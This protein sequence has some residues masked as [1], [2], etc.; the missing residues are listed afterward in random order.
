M[1]LLEIKKRDAQLSNGT[2]FAQG[3]AGSLF[4]TT[5]DE[6]AAILR[7]CPLSSRD[8]AFVHEGLTLSRASADETA[9][10]ELHLETRRRSKYLAMLAK[11][12]ST[13]CEVCD[14]DFGSV[15]GKLG[16]GF[17]E[18]HHDPPL[19]LLN[20]DTTLN[21]LHTVCANCHRMLHRN[22]IEPIAID[23]LRRIIK[24]ANES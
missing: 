3:N 9:A 2:A 19:S 8:A 16:E 21:D 7:H 17:I 14:F 1:P 11:Q 23:A 20:R 10:A 15:Y 18:V 13:I 5:E 22:G 4:R 24:E 6:S 12:G